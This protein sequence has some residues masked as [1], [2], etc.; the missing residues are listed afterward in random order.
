MNIKF[1]DWLPTAVLFL[2][3]LSV[4]HIALAAKKLVPE[5]YE[6]VGTYPDGT[7]C[8]TYDLNGISYQ[9]TILGVGS[10]DC[11]IGTVAGP[12]SSVPGVTDFIQSPNIEGASAGVLHMTFDSPVTQFRF[13]MAT[14]VEVNP[15]ASPPIPQSVKLSLLRLKSGVFQDGADLKLLLEVA[16][17]ENQNGDSVD[18]YFFG[19]LYEY[20][21]PAVKAAAIGWSDTSGR[22]VIDNVAYFSAPGQA[23]KDD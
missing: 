2:V 8:E 15:G 5:E 19:G 13:G 6:G 11:N 18:R 14:V 4:S 9:F 3:A 22:M 17:V 16:D 1:N 7:L 12:P 20:M 21:G 23:K 10:R